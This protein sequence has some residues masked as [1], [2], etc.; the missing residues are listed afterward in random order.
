M[1]RSPAG[2]PR[3]T[4]SPRR[5][6]RQ[7]AATP[8]SP[9]P[10][11]APSGSLLLPEAADGARPDVLVPRAPVPAADPPDAVDPPRAAAAPGD[12]RRP[13]GARPAADRGADAEARPPAERE[14]A[15]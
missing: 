9:S 3:L 14:R 15:G 2:S 5:T 8:R 6:L 13:A 4:R 12:P 10:G 7:C 11:C 1:K